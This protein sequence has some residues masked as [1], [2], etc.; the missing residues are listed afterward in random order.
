MCVYVYMIVRVFLCICM[1]IY[2]S[3]H[4]FIHPSIHLSI[5]R[6]LGYA[7]TIKKLQ[8]VETKMH[9]ML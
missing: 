9:F 1:Y 8:Y 5:S 4:P 3:I 6:K 2:L 7:E